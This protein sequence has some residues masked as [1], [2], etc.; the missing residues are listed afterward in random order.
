MTDHKPP[1]SR[2]KRKRQAAIALY[3]PLPASQAVL[4]EI[5]EQLASPRSLDSRGAAAVPARRSSPGDAR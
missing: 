2:S 1:E 5:P 4:F 3:A